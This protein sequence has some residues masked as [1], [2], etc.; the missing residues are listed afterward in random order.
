MLLEQ[1]LA[2]K[3]LAA[4][5]AEDGVWV[6]MT[7]LDV[8]ADVG[9]RVAVEL[10]HA[11]LVVFLAL[12]SLE[13]QLFVLGVPERTVADVAHVLRLLVDQHVL[14]DVR[15][16]TAPVI[17]AGTLE[18]LVGVVGAGV[19]LEVGLAIELLA[20]QRALEEHLGRHV[21]HLEVHL[22]DVR[23]LV[24]LVAHRADASTQLCVPCHVAPDG[25]RLLGNVVAVGADAAG[26]LRSVV[27]NE[28]VA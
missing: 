1:G 5:V 15:P 25:I 2:L 28:R 10:A 13:V 22:E 21:H 11:A 17:T 14:G 27:N 12:V 8:L 4:P 19:S 26:V 20:T 7:P 9:E 6:G 24:T 3:G 16:L 18:W 23:V